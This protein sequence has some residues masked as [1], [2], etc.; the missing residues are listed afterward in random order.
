[1]FAKV[2]LGNADTFENISQ[3]HA[4][5]SIGPFTVIGE[6]EFGAFRARQLPAANIIR[7]DVAGPPIAKLEPAQPIMDAG[8]TVVQVFIADEIA[9]DRRSLP[10]KAVLA[11]DFRVLAPVPGKERPH[12]YAA[13]IAFWIAV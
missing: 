5:A 2:R 11:R 4:Q 13:H 6:T 1:D 7:G 10:F 12:E 8:L 3:H 9:F